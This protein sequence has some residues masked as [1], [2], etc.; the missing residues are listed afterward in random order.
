[1]LGCV[2]EGA[3]GV[4]YLDYM[5]QHIFGPAGMTH[6]RL[7][8][9]RE[10]IPHRVSGYMLDSAGT[11]HNS[12]HDDMSN[13]IPAGGWVSTAEDLA[14]FGM[15]YIDGTL[16][17][18]SARQ[19][20]LR[21]PNGSNGQPIKDDGYAL[22]WAISDWYGVQEVMHGGGTPQVCALLYLLPERRFVVAFMMN[23]EA[24]PDRGDL[25]GDLAK[26]VLG[27]RAP[28]R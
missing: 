25:A 15:R 24:V 16:I 23:L 13:R 20:M 6:T 10:I 11:L 8:D 3:A 28:H 14:H 26:V 1:V 9:A 7:D 4:P 17:T 22:G 12:V 5:T 19:A 21:V 27:P 2:I 18:D